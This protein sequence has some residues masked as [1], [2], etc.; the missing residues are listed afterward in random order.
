MLTRYSVGVNSIIAVCYHYFTEDWYEVSR[1]PLV[2]ATDCFDLQSLP[3]KKNKLCYKTKIHL[4][5][6]GSGVID[7]PVD[8]SNERDEHYHLNYNNN[9][10]HGYQQ[11]F[12]R[13]IDVGV[14]GC[15]TYLEAHYDHGSAR[16]NFRWTVWLEFAI[17]F[18]ADNGGC[19]NVSDSDTS[20]GTNTTSSVSDRD[21]GDNDNTEAQESR[22]HSDE[23]TF[24]LGKLVAGQP[25]LF[26]YSGY[27]H[28]IPWFKDVYRETLLA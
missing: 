8:I 16:G 22:I 14:C 12:I 9:H 2:F 19:V 3:K 13:N 1:S 17:A 27:E 7:G 23:M 10:L 18:A 20:T 25:R 21:N 24:E 4:K 28:S 15:D 5:L 11:W 6:D 26:A